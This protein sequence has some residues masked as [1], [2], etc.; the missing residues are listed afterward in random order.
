MRV[1]IPN[2]SRKALAI[3]TTGVI[4]IGVVLVYIKLKGSEQ[5]SPKDLLIQSLIDDSND[6]QDSEVSYKKTTGSLDKKSFQE[7][8]LVRRNAKLMIKV[9]LIAKGDRKSVV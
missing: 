5:L 6:L 4:S 2:I 3:L 8:V 9:G 1:L 7:Q